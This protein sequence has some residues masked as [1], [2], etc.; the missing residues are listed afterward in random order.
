[1]EGRGG[2]VVGQPK[3]AKSFEKKNNFMDELCILY[4]YVLPLRPKH[5]EREGKLGVET[6]PFS[7]ND[8]FKTTLSYWLQ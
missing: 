1:M 6:S 4:A 2:A 5:T 7:I 3:W 8:R